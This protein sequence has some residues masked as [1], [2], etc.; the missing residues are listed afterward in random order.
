MAADKH[1]AGSLWWLACPELCQL[2][3]QHV[4]DLQDLARPGRAN[5]PK[6]GLWGKACLR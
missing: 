2:L 3:A 4:M 5:R 6:Q 1:G